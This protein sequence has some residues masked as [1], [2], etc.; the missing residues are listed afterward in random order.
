VTGPALLT[1]SAQEWDTAVIN[2]GGHFL[3]SFRWGAFKAEFGWDVE[4]VAPCDRGLVALAQVLFRSKGPVGVGYIPRGPVLPPASAG[5]APALFREIDA[6]ARSR[7]ALYVHAEPDQPLPLKG[8]FRQHGF[9]AG[10]DH[11]QPARTVKVPLLEDDALL[12]QMRQNTRY[13]VR[14]AI[15]RNV[16]IVPIGR[17]YA[18]DDFYGLLAETADRNSF[19]IR[20]KL[21]Y[22]RFLE[23]FGED[24]LCLFA[25]A[26]QNLAAALISVKFGSEAIYMY[27]A[28]SSQH[29]AHGAAFLLQY[30]AMRWARSHGCERY[31]LW[32]IPLEDP[33]NFSD[34]GE[35]LAGTKGDDWRGLYRFKTGFG[36]EIVNYPPSLERRY[37]VLGSLVARRILGRRQGD[38]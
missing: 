17:E 18:I 25:R 29:R 38:T 10:P 20:E 3:Q 22:A 2:A 32:G 31:D 5:L 1:S 6:R 4:R 37:S 8:S 13:S 24:A 26:D 9:V 34:S 21:Y 36:G 15:R 19:G 23:I 33:Q 27:G 14:L 16:E 35:T 12:A 30:E 11:I 7:R 28:S